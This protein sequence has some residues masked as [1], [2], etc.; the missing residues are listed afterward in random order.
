MAEFFGDDLTI[1]DMNNLEVGDEVTPIYTEDIAGIVSALLQNIDV[2]LDDDTLNRIDGLDEDGLMSIM[3]AASTSL[4]LMQD[5]RNA[6]AQEVE[7]ENDLYELAVKLRV[8]STFKNEWAVRQELESDP[9]A[10]QAALDVARISRELVR[11][12]DEERET[13]TEREFAQDVLT[14]DERWIPDRSKVWTTNENR[15]TFIFKRGSWYLVNQHSETK[16]SYPHFGYLDEGFF[17]M[18]KG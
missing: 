15:G 3:L 10:L 8:A 5:E 9:Q 18:V 17:P 14:F 4:K 6:Q 1:T 7:D 12:Y 11:E 13:A 16:Y 2:E